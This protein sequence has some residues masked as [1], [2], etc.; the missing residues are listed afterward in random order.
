M[1]FRIGVNVGDVMVK[2]DDIFGDG[3]NVAAW[4]EGLVK[5]GEI[6]V[7]REY[8]IT[9]VIAAKRLATRSDFSSGGDLRAVRRQ[10]GQPAVWDSVKDGSPAELESYIEQ[11]PRQLR[12]A[13]PNTT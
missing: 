1:R 11:Y 9:C 2:D 3:V 12:L 8:A 7:S 6:C 4:P 13:R 5:G 10:R